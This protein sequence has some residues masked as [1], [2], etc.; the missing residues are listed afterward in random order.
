MPLLLGTYERQIMESVLSARAKLLC[1]HL[2]LCRG[3][4]Q[5]PAHFRQTAAP[6]VKIPA[7]RPAS[8]DA[9]RV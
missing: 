6:R 9:I 3:E 8:W 2:Q 5:Q 7:R 1:R 4:P